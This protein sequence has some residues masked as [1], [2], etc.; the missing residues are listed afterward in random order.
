MAIA[1]TLQRYLADHGIAY[2]VV[3]HPRTVSSTATAR[4]SHVSGD[5]LAKAVIVKDEEGFVVAVA[6][7]SHHVRLADLSRLLDRR[8]GLATEQEASALFG[9]CELGAFPAAG[10]AYGLAVAVDDSLAEQPEVY[11][12]GGDH[13]SLVQ[14]TAEQ[15][16]KLM[17]EAAH[18]R[19]SRHD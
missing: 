16:R 2:D 11:F 3:T 19:F 5:C 12:E 14:V 9:D 17:A 4:E 1:A 13:L 8:L 10:A 18:G 15:F 6:P 7:A